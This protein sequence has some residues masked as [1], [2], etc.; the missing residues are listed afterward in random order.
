M[1][2]RTALLVVCVLGLAVSAAVLVLLLPPLFSPGEQAGPWAVGV[3]AVLAVVFAG[4]CLR[5]GPSRRR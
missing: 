2:R 3:S 5:W 1:T 4:G